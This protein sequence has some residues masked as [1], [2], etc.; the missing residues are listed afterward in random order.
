MTKT[1]ELA[2]FGASLAENGLPADVVHCAKRA[3]IDWI[4]A[5]LAGSR[6]PAAARLQQ[7]IAAVATDEVATIVGTER[8]TSAPF[9]ALANGYA[10]H[11]Q[12]FDDVFNPV[13]TTVHLGS[14]VWPVVMALSQV[15]RLPGAGAVASFVAGFETGARVG[16][17]AGL[18]HYESSWQVTG[19][20]GHLASAAAGARALGLPGE[21]ATHALGMAAAQASGIREIYGS[22]TKALQPGK[23]AMDGVLAALLAEAGFTSRDT[24]LEGERGLL[25]A[26]SPSPD[27]DLLVDGLGV[28]W[29]LL[30]NGHKLYPSASLSHPAVDA[31]TAMARRPEFRADEVA[32]VEAR[33]LPFAAAVTSVVHPRPGSDAKFSAPH[34][35][36]VALLTGRLGLDDFGEGR[37]SDPDVTA[38]RGRI[39]VIGDPAVG[40]RAAVLTATLRDGTVLREEVEQNRGTPGNRLS[41]AELEAKF[42]QVA[43]PRIGAA[44]A[45]AVL[46]HC[47]DL[48]FLD[49][50]SLVLAP[51]RKALNGAA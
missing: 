48:D 38:L 20:A 13:Q 46:N 7:V 34:C 1:G 22:D 43:E 30:D 31:A 36:A 17:A 24:A 14:C 35:L 23:A 39:G 40:K 41:D 4:A 51:L 12:D 27:A 8:M 16:C 19:T 45:S 9:A 26:I 50:A 18:A 11:L 47:W 49:D 3:L 21:A 42:V 44:A 29:H 5:A 25:G 2:R 15:R 10:S 6:E 32:S 28:R 37:V 33:M